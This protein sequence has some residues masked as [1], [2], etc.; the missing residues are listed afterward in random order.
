MSCGHSEGNKTRE[1]DQWDE[2]IFKLCECDLLQSSMSFEWKDSVCWAGGVNMHMHMV[3]C[4]QCGQRQREGI[5]DYMDRT[6]YNLEGMKMLTHK[7]MAHRRSIDDGGG[8]GGGGRQIIS[9]SFSFFSSLMWMS[10][11]DRHNGE[12]AN[13][14]DRVCV[15]PWV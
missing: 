15:C 8:G 11:G 14:N 10:R 6:I 4:D 5:T 3:W 9:P 12:Q 2:N 13:N 1:G 7:D